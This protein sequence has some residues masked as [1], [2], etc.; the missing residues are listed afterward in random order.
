MTSNEILGMTRHSALRNDNDLNDEDLL[1]RLAAEE[2]HE[3]DDEDY[4]HH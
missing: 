4:Y 2:I 3:L 1:D